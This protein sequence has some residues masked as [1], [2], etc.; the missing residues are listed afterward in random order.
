MFLPWLSGMKC[1]CA[2]LHGHLW[3][4]WLYYIFPHYLTNDTI[5]GLN[6]LRTGDTDFR[7]YITTVQDGLRKSAKAPE[8]L[9]VVHRTEHRF[10]MFD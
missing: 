8:N 6:T 10:F 9:P 4:F 1:A 3:T 5:F 2:V 7:F